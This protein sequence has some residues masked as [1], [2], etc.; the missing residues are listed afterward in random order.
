V[1][2]VG[3]CQVY[4]TPLTGILVAGDCVASL[5][6]P[7]PTVIGILAGTIAANAQAI[8]LMGTILLLFVIAS[9]CLATTLAGLMAW[10]KCRVCV[11]TF[12]RTVLVFGSSFLELLATIQAI[13][14]FE[15]LASKMCAFVGAVLSPL[16][17]ANKA[18]AALLADMLAHGSLLGFTEAIN[19]AVLTVGVLGS[20]EIHPADRAGKILVI[21]PTAVVTCTRAKSSGVFFTSLTVT[22]KALAALLASKVVHMSPPM[23]A[24]RV[25]SRGSPLGGRVFGC[26]PSPMDSIA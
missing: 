20:G 25:L 12:Q 17:V 24:P 3:A 21:F 2:D 7:V 6:R 18:F 16:F 22:G 26:D 13:S 8:A 9:E 19:R 5:F 23:T 15:F 4:A 1:M 10:E 14:R 11:K